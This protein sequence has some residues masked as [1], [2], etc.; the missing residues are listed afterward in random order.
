MYFSRFGMLYWKKSGNP[1]LETRPMKNFL[2][3]EN[4]AVRKL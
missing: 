1:A 2:P 3:K 4:S